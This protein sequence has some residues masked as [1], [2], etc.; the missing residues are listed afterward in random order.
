MADG[1][2]SAGGALEHA[3]ARTAITAATIARVRRGERSCFMTGILYLERLATARLCDAL[4]LTNLFCAISNCRKRIQLHGGTLEVGFAR[5]APQH[6][7]YC[8]CEY[9][10]DQTTRTRTTRARPAVEALTDFLANL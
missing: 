3:A 8:F 2:T 4:P 7:Y 1:P 5:I 10:S 9:R 6:L